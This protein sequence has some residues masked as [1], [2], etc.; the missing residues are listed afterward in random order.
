M[1][2]EKN[3]YS[4][5]ELIE[6]YHSGESDCLDELMSRYS[7]LARAKARSCFL[8]GGEQEDLVQEGMIGIFKAVK[9]FQQDKNSSFKTFANMCVSRQIATAIRCSNRY[10]HIPLNNSVSFN[11]S[12]AEGFEVKDMI[13]GNERSPEEI[14][15]ERESAD[16]LAANIKN[17]L[18]P[19]EKRVLYKYIQG[20]TYRQIA[21][22]LLITEKT[23]D[24]ALQRIKKKLL[25]DKN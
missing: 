21:S 12:V 13:E 18:S 20:L 14:L 22:E 10:K 1:F 8:I 24:N 4:D 5:E 25:A 23:I 17:R 9:D 15:I 7:S 16:T 11:Q 2:W 19:L 6:K 3:V